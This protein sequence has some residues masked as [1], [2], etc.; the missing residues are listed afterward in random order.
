MEHLS[1]LSVNTRTQ[2]PIEEYHRTDIVFCTSKVHNMGQQPSITIYYAIDFAILST[3]K[4]D[5]SLQQA[6]LSIAGIKACRDGDLRCKDVVLLA[7][8]L[9]FD[10]ERNDE[11]ILSELEVRPS[12]DLEEDEDEEVFVSDDGDN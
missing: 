5:T 6:A 4:V 12:V 2:V 11:K 10:V 1:R 3:R 7:H 8:D 9:G